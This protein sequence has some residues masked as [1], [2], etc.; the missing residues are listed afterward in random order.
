[1][2]ILTFT[3]LYPNQAMP[4]RG[5]FVENRLRHVVRDM[6]VESRVVSPIPWFPFGDR[7]A[8]DY[9]AFAKVPRQDERH[10]IAIRYPR[11]L[12]LPKIGMTAQPFLMAAAARPVLRQMIRDGYDFD[13]IDA[14]YFYPDGVAAALLARSLDKPLVI[15]ARGTDINLIPQYALPRRLIQWAAK[16]ADHMIT[17]CQALNDSLVELGADPAKVTT[18]RNGVDLSSFQPTADREQQRQQ[19]GLSGT[20]IVSVGY[21]IPRK[22]HDLVIRALA[23]LPDATLLI[24]GDGPERAALEGLARDIGVAGRV[25][26]TGAIP[27]AVLPRFYGA[28]DVMVL[29]SSREG[30]ANVLLESMACGTPVVATRV[31]GTPEVVATSE[32]GRLADERTP[33]SIRD[34]IQAL[35]ADYP[36]RTAT[37]RYA[38]QF[39]WDDTTRGQWEIFS[40][41]CAG[42]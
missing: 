18:L 25:R 30:W 22:G 36:D 37:R 38:E 31:W 23:E 26:F 13:L 40:R 10:G 21:L 12:N 24:I 15:T 19:L 7:L 5:V 27:H 14:H 28:A 20:V 17:V 2:R 3:S 34:A 9:A 4:S 33:Q 39:S 8:S 35:L 16:R 32:A 42:R 11:Y 41:L 1:M 6:D 29:A